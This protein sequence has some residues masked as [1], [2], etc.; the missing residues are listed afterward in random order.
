M[1]P[2]TRAQALAA[3]APVPDQQQGA[4]LQACLSAYK[5]FNSASPLS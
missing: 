1:G 4:V 5:S 3:M 2:L